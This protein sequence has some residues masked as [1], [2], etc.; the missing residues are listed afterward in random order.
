MKKLA[1]DDETYEWFKESIEDMRTIYADKERDD[2]WDADDL[3]KDIA[4]KL[5]ELMQDS[6]YRAVREKYRISN[7]ED[8]LYKT[9]Q[10]KR[11]FDDLDA[12]VEAYKLNDK[13]QYN[14]G[15]EFNPTPEEVELILDV[16]IER[17]YRDYA[18]DEE[19]EDMRRSINKVTGLVC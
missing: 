17:R 3:A 10:R 19:M 15:R 6:D 5:G 11:A 1:I 4:E 8:K 7:E 12:E 18:I 16:Y 9:V 13:A 2:W 14:D